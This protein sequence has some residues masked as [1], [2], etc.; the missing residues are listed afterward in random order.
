MRRSRR[1]MALFK[2]FA[3]IITL[4]LPLLACAERLPYGVSPRHYSLTFIPDLQ[5]AVFGGD[6]T[7]DVEVNKA[8]NSITLN[9]IE[10][11]LQEATVTQDNKSQAA[12]RTFTPE[13]EQ[14]TLTVTDELQPGPAR[15]HFNFTG[16]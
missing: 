12:K 14:V 11:E 9:A 6:A 3:L 10:L 4:M 1:N 5:K 13:K 16:V 15:I 7:I 8:T 2:K